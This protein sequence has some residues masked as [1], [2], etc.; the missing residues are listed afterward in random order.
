MG[1]ATVMDSDKAQCPVCGA[2][3]VDVDVTWKL[4]QP[5]TFSLA[6]VAVKTTGHQVPKASCR[7]CPWS[8]TG[9]FETGTNGRDYACFKQSH[10]E[11]ESVTP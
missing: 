2:F 9:R 1:E 7:S 11:C 8:V 5:G 10:A 6:G 4:A 3:G